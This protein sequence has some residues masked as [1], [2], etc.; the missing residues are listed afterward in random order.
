[1]SMLETA[2]TAKALM[3]EGRGILAMDESVGTCN[4]RFEALGIPSTFEMRRDYRELLLGTPGLGAFISGAIVCDETF[5][6]SRA[7]GAPL[8]DLAAQGGILLG[9]KVDAGAVPMALHPGERVTEGLDGLRQRLDLY[10]SQGARFAKWRAVL[11]V[12]ATTPSRGC[13]AANAM[14]LALYA[15]LCQEAGLLPIVEAEVLMDGSHDLRRCYWVT[16]M[17]LHTVFD[18]LYAQRIDLGG[19][20]LKPNMVLPGADSTQQPGAREVAEATLQ[21]LLATVPAAVPG[22]AF[23]SGGQSPDLATERLKAIHDSHGG[24]APWRLT[25]SFS[26]ALQVPVLALWGGKT[27]QATQAQAVLLER[28]AANGAASMGRDPSLAQRL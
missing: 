10:Y 3:A 24:K 1:M 11:R 4:R 15:G 14:G 12:D 16:E 23:L 22:I 13:L 8:R 25:F 27:A 5:M 20:L 6:Q 2:I 19:M 26:R 21:C 28:A 9:V 7:D 18:A 17:V